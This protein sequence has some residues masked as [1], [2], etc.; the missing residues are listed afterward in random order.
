MAYIYL[1]VAFIY[2]LPAAIFFWLSKDVITSIAKKTVKLISS[3]ISILS[4]KG[5]QVLNKLADVKEKYKGSEIKNILKKEKP[6]VEQTD[7]PPGDTATEEKTDDVSAASDG[8]VGEQMTI[9]E[10]MTEKADRDE[11]STEETTK[12]GVEVEE[13]VIEEP[14]DEESKAEAPVT[15]EE[16][17]EVPVIDEEK[18]EVPVTEEEKTEAPVTE[19]KK[20][21]APVTEKEKTEPPVTEATKPTENAAGWTATE[22]PVIEKTAEREPVDILENV[23]KSFNSVIGDL[24][25]IRLGKERFEKA[26]DDFEESDNR[27]SAAGIFLN[28]FAGQTKFQ[29]DIGASDVIDNIKKQFDNLDMITTSAIAI[30][31]SDTKSKTV[32]PYIQSLKKPDIRVILLKFCQD[33]YFATDIEQLNKLFSKSYYKWKILRYLGRIT[34][35]IKRGIGDSLPRRVA[36]RKARITKN[37]FINK[38]CETINTFESVKYISALSGNEEISDS[39]RNY[40]LDHLSENYKDAL[41]YLVDL[42]LTCTC[43]SK[44]LFVERMIKNI[45]ENSE[46]NKIITNMARSIDDH[47]LIISKSRPIYKQYYQSELGYINGDDFLYGLAITIMVNRVKKVEIK[48]REILKINTQQQNTRDFKQSMLIWLDELSRDDNVDDIGTLILQK[49]T[50]SVKNNFGLLINALQE[51]TNWE[52]YYSQRVLYYEKARDRERYLKGDFEQEK[53]ELIRIK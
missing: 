52:N 7:S 45:N 29:K 50:L 6:T 21:E 47:N 49:I 26:H 46:F 27:S 11:E 15:D 10:A 5:K 8:S 25:K 43:I 41:I 2:I 35:F 9:D 48:N 36:F 18:T 37:R 31:L 17:T 19:E 51:L 38:I 39:K 42:L 34:V 40:K 28:R 4:G 30:M 20:T 44:M 23:K 16:K 13:A 24:K 22:A 53:E 14:S 3:C 33:T 12:E 32:S 1:P